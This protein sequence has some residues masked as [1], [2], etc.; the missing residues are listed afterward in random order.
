[1]VVVPPFAVFVPGLGFLAL[2]FLTLPAYALW[3]VIWVLTIIVGAS[4]F[5]RRPGAF[6]YA[7]GGVRVD[8]TLAWIYVGSFVLWAAALLVDVPALAR[9]ITMVP[10]TLIGTAAAIWLIVDWFI[11]IARRRRGRLAGGIR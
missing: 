10:T 8:R 6:A 11:A 1:M 9:S 5:V 3:L 4:G 7:W 2:W